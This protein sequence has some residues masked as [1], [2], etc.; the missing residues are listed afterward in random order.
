MRILFLISVIGIFLGC[1]SRAPRESIPR[2]PGSEQTISLSQLQN[3]LRLDRSLQE[4]GLMDKIFDSCSLPVKDPTGKCGA[5]YFSV[6]HFQMVCRDSEGTVGTVVTNT[7]P[8]VSDHV[9]YQLAG[10]RGII[11]TDGNGYGQLQ[12]VTLVPVRGQR[13]VLTVGREFLGKE[14]SEVEQL[15]VPN[16][17]CQ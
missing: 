1:A 9:E 5:R 8:L 15:V 17:W 3:Q 16:Y 12:I 2:E 6:L 14:I 4:L 13:L 7:R 11:K 10:H